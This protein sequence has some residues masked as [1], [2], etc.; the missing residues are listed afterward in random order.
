MSR[1][2]RDKE[3]EQ[4]PIAGG[5]VEL[6]LLIAAVLTVAYVALWFKLDVNRVFDVPKAYALKV[7]G[8]GAYLAWLMFSLFGRGMRW[9]SI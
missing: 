1:K 9:G 8:G 7:G 4:R 5:W 3:P 2:A 6:A